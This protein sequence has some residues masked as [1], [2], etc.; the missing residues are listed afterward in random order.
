MID[1]GE[2]HWKNGIPACGVIIIVYDKNLT[3][4]APGKNRS[5]RFIH[6]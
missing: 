1:M 2:G 3:Y 6:G 5:P 4:G